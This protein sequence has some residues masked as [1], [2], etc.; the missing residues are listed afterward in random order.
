MA[1]L[2]VFHCKET[3]GK[4]RRIARKGVD[5]PAQIL[6][7]FTETPLRSICLFFRMYADVR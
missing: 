5:N 7:R 4:N 2:I 6:E 3:W 1:K